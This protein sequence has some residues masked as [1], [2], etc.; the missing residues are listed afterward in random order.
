MTKVLLVPGKWL[1]LPGEYLPWLIGTP[2][3]GCCFST[4]V[5][6][7]KRYYTEYPLFEPVDAKGTVRE[8]PVAIAVCYM[9][10]YMQA[11]EGSIVYNDGLGVV[12]RS[13]DARNVDPG[14]QV[15]ILEDYFIHS[16]RRPIPALVPDPIA[17]PSG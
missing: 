15:K 10:K 14:E 11:A 17:F 9:D 2:L 16:K 7:V 1:I 13:Y 3:K 8:F 6:S 12:R 4:T 5:A